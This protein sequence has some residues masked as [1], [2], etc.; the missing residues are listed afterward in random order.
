MEKIDRMPVFVKVARLM[1]ENLPTDVKVGS[2]VTGPFTLAGQLMG[3]TNLFMATI[4]K[5]ELA[6]DT[7]RLSSQVIDK[8]VKSLSNTHIDFL[9]LAERALVSNN[10]KT[11]SIPTPKATARA[12]SRISQQLLPE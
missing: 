4:R 9:V 11:K 1:A 6:K 7:V 3:I 2:F 10:A 12:P 5:H 8:Y